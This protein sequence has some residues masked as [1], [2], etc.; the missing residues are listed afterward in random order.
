MPKALRDI[1]PKMVSTTPENTK[2]HLEGDYSSETVKTSTGEDPGVDYA[3]KSPDEQ[4]FVGKHETKKN[5]ER[6]G[7]KGDYRNGEKI[8][9][10]LKTIQGKLMGRDKKEAESVYESKKIKKEQADSP[11]K[12][13]G[14]VPNKYQSGAADAAVEI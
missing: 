1:T 13:S 4:K 3:P 11:I 12:P 6:T 14:D 5:A 9:Y 8:K 7:N 10:S 2:K